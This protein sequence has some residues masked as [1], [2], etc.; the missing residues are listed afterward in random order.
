MLAITEDRANRITWLIEC[1]CG[2]KKKK[3]IKDASKVL[4]Q[5]TE[6]IELP[7]MEIGKAATRRVLGRRIRCSIWKS[8]LR[9]LL[10]PQVEIPCISRWVCESEVGNRGLQLEVISM[11]P[12]KLWAETEKRRKTSL[13]G[14]QRSRVKEKRKG[15]QRYWGGASEVRGRHGA[16]GVPGFL[17]AEWRNCLKEERVINY[18]RSPM[19]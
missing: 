15:H 6:R 10:D 14:A 18:G 19:S 13:C 7:S 8:S 2:R 16:Q 5:A 12:T 3:R 4:A 11:I 9:C 1:G 17:E